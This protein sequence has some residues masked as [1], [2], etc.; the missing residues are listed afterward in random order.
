MVRFLASMLTAA[1]LAS[2]A[3]AQAPFPSRTVTMIVGF[4]PGGGTDIASRIIAKKLSENI[5]Q[6][7]VVENRAGAGGNIATELVARSQPDGYT[8]LLASVGSLSV[9]PHIV[10]KLP[11]DPVRDLAPVTMAVMFPNVLVVHPSVAAQTLADFVRLARAKPGSI[12][13]GSSGIGGA[14]HLAGELFRMMAKVDIVHVPYKG[15]GPA[16]TDLLAGQVAAVFATPASAGQ[17]V[18]AGKLRALAV[19]GVARSPSMPDVPT[20]AESGYPG[21]EATNWYAYVVAAKTPKDIVERWN[22][23]LVKVLTAPDVREQ[24][25]GHGLE[26]QPGTAE[27]LAKHI[28]RELA[29]WSRVVKE[30]GI[31]A[32]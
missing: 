9:A 6:S 29:T 7:V 3:L 1:L 4:A 21:Y 31:T 2:S 17:H 8:L 22:R 20:V 11:Y 30:A 28:E 15:G 19:T 27:A 26:P 14:G 16:V 10:A 25:L 23:E 18:K 32:N 5:G 13:Y 12:N 24:L